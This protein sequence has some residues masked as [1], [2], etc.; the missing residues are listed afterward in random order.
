MTNKE[1]R[2]EI[3]NILRRDRGGTIEAHL[4]KIDIDI[5]D[6]LALFKEAGYEKLPSDQKVEK[7]YSGGMGTG[8]SY[9][10]SYRTE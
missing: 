7:G 5:N 10:G 3:G 6:M 1:L 4:G 8:S 2:R 9:L